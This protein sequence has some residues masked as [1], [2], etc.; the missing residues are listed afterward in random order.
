MASPAELA[1]QSLA[2]FAPVIGR[3]IEPGQ[4][5]RHRF[6]RDAKGLAAELAEHRVEGSALVVV[7]RAELREVGRQSVNGPALSTSEQREQRVAGLAYVLGRRV[8][9][10]HHHR[11]VGGRRAGGRRLGKHGEQRVQSP[12]LVIWFWVQLENQ[13]RQLGGQG[14]FGLAEEQERSWR[15]TPG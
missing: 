4:R 13:V 7:C 6:R 2:G 11:H 10:G 5:G 9:M 1:E 8:E 14:A 3:G 12:A 15:T